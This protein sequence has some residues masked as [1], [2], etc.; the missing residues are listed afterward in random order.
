MAFMCSSAGA[1]ALASP[2]R[3]EDQLVN[4]A[5]AAPPPVTEI[6]PPP[7]GQVPEQVTVT[8]ERTQLLGIATTSSQG[9]VVQ[10]ELQLTPAYRAGQLLETV[11][12]LVVTAHSG[13]G[14]AN[15][16]LL[17][18]FNL[19]HGT[20][21]ATFIDNMPANMPTHAHGQGY[22]DLNFLI[23]ELV[24]S[25]QFTKGPYFAEEG[26]FS[27]V[28]SDH[29]GILD[30]ADNQAAATVGTL[31]FQRLFAE[32]SRNTGNATLLGAL[33]LVHYDGPWTHS[34]D[35]R[36]INAVARYS[37]GD[38]GNGY[39]VT[40]MYYRSLWNA[41]T[42]QPI[43]AMTSPYM[44]SLG[45]TPIDRF[46]TLD[47]S[48]G[49]QAQRMSLSG[50]YRVDIGPGHFDADAYTIYNRLTLWNDF[51]HFLANPINGDQ[52][53]QNEN[54][55]VVGG[56][57]DY[58][59]SGK[60]LG[61]DNDLL[62]GIQTRYD[63]NHVSRDAT[64]DR[65]YLSTTEDDRVRLL[66]L[67][68]YAQA[69]THW[70]DWMRT[71]FGIR[72]DYQTATDRGTNAGDVSASLFQPK[73]SLILSPWSNTEFYLSAGRGFH[74]DDVRGVTQAE[75]QGLAGAPLLARSTGEE[76]GVRSTI[77]PNLTATLTAFQIDFQSETTYDPDVGQDSPGPPS[78]RIGLE[79]NTTYQPFE[80]LELYTS[81]AASHARFT[82]PYDD[83]TGHVGEYIPNAP[84]VIGS[85]AA[86]LRNLGPWSGGIEY[87]Y[88]GAF[89]LTPDNA[90]TGKGYGEVNLE[91]NYAFESGW[92]IG[93]GIYNLLDV[94]AN[95][96]EFWYIDRLQGEPA[97]GVA[98]LHV[99]PLEPLAFRV[100]LGK[101]F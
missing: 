76:I 44:S 42:D 6:A 53:A 38:A 54:R 47:P 39:S 56:A 67:G 72:G 51:T 77:L 18:G 1:I 37:E 11:P 25:V 4:L 28:G 92:K 43:R 19:D 36:K 74:S 98:D 65:Q 69:T 13:E 15:Q 32:G 40:A 16:Y 83:R 7:A 27:S 80:W 87:R 58:E 22:T 35:Q 46:G 85:V 23:P 68:A 12:G 88:L 34:D 81:I 66:S 62:T 95:A 73:G 86:Y 8:A 10:Q 96:A 60:V 17:R 91:G 78:R 79:F 75:R 97:G 29:I 82:E 31:G 48:D 57:A 99:H 63:D 61:F 52:E 55:A 89:P 49:G 20:D 101:T 2:L 33:E 3:A 14:K 90:V 100:S 26:D 5:Q 64:K 21:L 9:E 50:Q 70:T 84:K 94:R 71:V 59:I 24:Q 30:V 93:L 45:L 41:T